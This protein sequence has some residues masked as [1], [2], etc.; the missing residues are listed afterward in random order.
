MRLNLV[1]KNASCREFRSCIRENTYNIQPPKEPKILG[2][3]V[4]LRKAAIR[5][6]NSSAQSAAWHP[7][8]HQKCFFTTW[9]PIGYERTQNLIHRSGRS[10]GK[11]ENQQ[12]ERFRRNRRYPN[13]IGIVLG[14]GRETCTSS[15]IMTFRFTPLMTQVNDVFLKNPSQILISSVLCDMI[16]R[17][18]DPT[19]NAIPQTI[20]EFCR[21]SLFLEVTS[22]GHVPTS[23]I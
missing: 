17:S 13:A 21:M 10:T 2:K 1:S 4:P 12:V 8:F 11:F 14:R 19:W 18:L 5:F 16:F 22:R 7:R 9:N 3:A 20:A 23:E 6:S 15:S